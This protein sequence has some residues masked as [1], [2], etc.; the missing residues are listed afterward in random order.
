[1]RKKTL[2]IMVLLLVA[3][4]LLSGCATPEAEYNKAKDQVQGAVLGYILNE[5]GGY[6]SCLHMEI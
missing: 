4:L 1:M 6:F 2:G 5:G 3:G